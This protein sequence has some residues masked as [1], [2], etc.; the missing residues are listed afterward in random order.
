MD[1]SNGNSLN[2]TIKPTDFQGKV[3]SFVG[4]EHQRW[5]VFSRSNMGFCFFFLIMLRIRDG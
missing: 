1:V 3:V 5:D 2:L 4:S